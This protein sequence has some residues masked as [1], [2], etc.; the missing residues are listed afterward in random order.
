MASS[1]SQHEIRA[2]QPR[3]PTT[4]SDLYVTYDIEEVT[5]SGQRTLEPHARRVSIGGEVREWQVGDFRRRSGREVHGIRIHYEQ[6]RKGYLRDGFTA[7]R[8][9]IT[10]EVPST[11][12]EPGTSMFTHIVELPVRA[13]NVQLHRGALPR[14]Y[15]EALRVTR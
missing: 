1:S 13:R 12:V 7:T 6:S 10:Y 14:R 4:V 5:A 3:Y 8:G 2:E 15:R 11:D 9:G